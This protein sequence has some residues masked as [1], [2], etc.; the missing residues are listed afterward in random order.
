MS[1]KSNTVR[2]GAVIAA[3]LTIGIGSITAANAT[4]LIKMKWIEASA[5]FQPCL[6]SQ[7][8]S[9]C[10]YSDFNDAQITFAPISD[11]DQFLGITG[12]GYFHNHP[13]GSS[14]TTAYLQLRLDT[15]WTTI[16]TQATTSSTPKVYLDSFPM[17]SFAAASL[18]GIRLYSDPNQDQSFHKVGSDYFRFSRTIPEPGT[19]ALFGLDLAGLGFARRKKAA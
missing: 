18:S 8:L 4:T 2:F 10:D 1:L 12:N 13:G 6:A 16:H 9:S 14:S 17:Y 19:L 7:S 5:S 3:V 11:I 15:V